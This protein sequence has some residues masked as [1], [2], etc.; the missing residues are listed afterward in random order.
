MK[1][2]KIFGTKKKVILNHSNTDILFMESISE[3]EERVIDESLE[4]YVSPKFAVEKDL[5]LLPSN[6]YLYGKL[7]LEDENDIRLIETK[8]IISLDAME[9]AIIDSNFNYEKGIVES[10]ENNEFLVHNTWDVLNW[11]KYNHCLLGKPERIIIYKL[12]RI[13]YF[14]HLHRQRIAKYGDSTRFAYR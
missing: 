8:D 3:E 13:D 11:F 4:N 14:N 5:I 6:I 7:D 1:T 2:R 12:K 10:N 9:A